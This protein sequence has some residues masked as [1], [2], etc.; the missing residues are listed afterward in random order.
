MIKNK[1]ITWIT[2][3]DHRRTS[4]I[5][6]ELNAELIVVNS[7]GPIWA[8]H[9]ARSLKT[10]SILRAKKDNV[11]IVQNPSRILAAIATLF[12]FF[13][14]YPLL[15]DRHTNFRLGKKVSFD[16]RIWFLILCSNFS[17]R[18]ADLT[19]VTNEFLKDLVERKGGRGFVLPDKIPFL[20]SDGLCDENI[21][22]SDG[23]ERVVFICTFADDEP[24]GSV[25]EAGNLLDRKI[26]IFITGNYKS[27]PKFAADD[28]PSN[29]KFTGFLPDS[30]YTKLLSSADVVIDF[31]SLEWCLVCGGYEALSLNKPLVTSNTQAL[32]EYF[33]DSAIF[34]THSPVA[35][36]H[37]INKAIDFKE[38][39]KQKSA[40]LKQKK[41]EE[42]RRQFKSLVKFID[43]SGKPPIQ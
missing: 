29:V 25:I 18:Y 12:S 1:S 15:V 22:G 37:A 6:A 11:I 31:T 41:E 16:P 14:G 26:Q 21:K 7:A 35:I 39:L 10:I 30:D 33:E 38:D 9:L 36:A 43:Q 23:R 28:L 4:E 19:I 42:W 34:S 40:Q 2:W 20:H 17:I 3:A 32:I 27:Q 24:Y 8:K 13:W 5:A